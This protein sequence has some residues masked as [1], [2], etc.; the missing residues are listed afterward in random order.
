MDKLRFN[1]HSAAGLAQEQNHNEKLSSIH[2]FNSVNPLVHLRNELLP[3]ASA[4]KATFAFSRKA[5]GA[6]AHFTYGLVARKAQGQQ[7]KK[8]KYTKP[9]VH[10]K[11]A[12]TLIRLMKK[13][14]KLQNI[15][16]NLNKYNLFKVF[17]PKFKLI[18]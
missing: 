9:N 4:A 12:R 15:L 1:L 18:C 16:F 3:V 17:S 14:T 2:T 11:V 8:M 6:D 10:W 5:Q 7:G 13:G